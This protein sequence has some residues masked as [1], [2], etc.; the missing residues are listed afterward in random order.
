MAAAPNYQAAQEN[1]APPPGYEIGGSYAPAGSTT[2]ELPPLPAAPPQEEALATAP[3]NYEV[4][5]AYY[6]P[7]GEAAYAYAPAGESYVYAPPG[8]DK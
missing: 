6:A 1:Y 4:V 8:N 5:Y 2:I 3:P 7:A